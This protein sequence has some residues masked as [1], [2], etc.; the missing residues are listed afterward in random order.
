MRKG[1]IRPLLLAAVLL[2]YSLSGCGILDSFPSLDYEPVVVFTGYFN[3]DFHKLTGNRSQPN[4][5]E[6]VGDT[7]RM[8]FFSS[9]FDGKSRT[10]RGD[11]LRI[12]LYRT[13]DSTTIHGTDNALVRLSR[14]A[15]GNAT[16]L[17]CAADSAWSPPLGS[18][19]YVEDLHN[20][21]G[22]TIRISEFYA[23][24]HSPHAYTTAMEIKKGEI[25]GRFDD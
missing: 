20:R 1:N 21:R 22:G 24:L 15:E 18:K 6:R 5:I 11:Q 25:F 10:W 2:V 13:N 23:A 7:I 17:V 14:Y 3:E 16:Y 4:T 12:D 8:Y 9:D 19:M